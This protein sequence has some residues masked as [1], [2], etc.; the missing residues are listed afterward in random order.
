MVHEGWGCGGVGGEVCPGGHMR[1][2]RT[3]HL[4]FLILIAVIVDSFMGG[5]VSKAMC[6]PLCRE[7]RLHECGMKNNKEWMF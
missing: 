2:P 7:K 3:K 4:N 1:G 6:I 5:Y